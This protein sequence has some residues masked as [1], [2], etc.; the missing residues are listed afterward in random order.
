MKQIR[1][2]TP[3]FGEYNISLLEKALGKSLLWPKNHEAIKGAKWALMIHHT[4]FQ[5]VMEIA[6]KILPEADLEPI[7]MTIPLQDLI[8][9]RGVLMAGVIDQCVR[10]DRQLLISTP[11][12]IWAEGSLHNMQILAQQRDTCIAVPHPRVLTSILDFIHEKPLEPY[13]LVTLHRKHQHR[14]WYTSEI[15]H[16][17]TGT[18][19]GGILWRRTAP[20]IVTLSHRMPSPYLLNVNKDDL[21]FFQ[22][23]AHA[24]GAIDHDFTSNLIESERL[25]TVLSSDLAF[26]AEVTMPNNNVPPPEAAAPNEPDAYWKQERKEHLLCHRMNRQF[27]CTFRGEP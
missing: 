11:D 12:F 26:M 2:F 4:E 22:H 15:G 19:K 23:E 13:D 18:W 21:A 14:S 20:G 7:E 6:T 24:F 17:P 3:V 16:N 5:R 1:I 27:I 8:D 9:K 25:R 10:E